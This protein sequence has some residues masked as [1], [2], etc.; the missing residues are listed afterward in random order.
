MNLIKELV[1]YL[2]VPALLTLALVGG[3]RLT[4]DMITYQHEVTGHAHVAV[5]ES[6]TTSPDEMF[7]DCAWLDT[8]EVNDLR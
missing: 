7:N 5:D 2:V 1:K 8:S 3:V 4:V 6:C